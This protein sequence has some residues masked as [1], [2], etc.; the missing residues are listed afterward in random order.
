MVRH[1]AASRIIAR[2]GSA[3]HFSHNSASGDA[4]QLYE[5]HSANDVDIAL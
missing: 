5:F 4:D 3:L 1:F 2:V